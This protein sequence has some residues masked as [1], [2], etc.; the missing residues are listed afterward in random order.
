MT[1]RRRATKLGQELTQPT[2]GLA[3]RGHYAGR[4]VESSPLAIRAHLVAKLLLRHVLGRQSLLDLVEGDAAGWAEHALASLGPNVDA[5]E[6][7][8]VS[9]DKAAGGSANKPS[10]QNKKR[11]RRRSTVKFKAVMRSKL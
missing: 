8:G 2:P 5:A 7:E 11:H 1:I 6:A 4:G 3:L 9:L 10:P